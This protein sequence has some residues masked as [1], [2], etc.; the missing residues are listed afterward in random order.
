MNKKELIKNIKF[1]INDFIA[2]SDV[3]KKN[4]GEVMT[5]LYLVDD[6]L[7]LLPSDVWSNPKLKW[8]DPCNGVGTF[9]CQIVDR[10]MTGLK[11][12]IPNEEERYSHIIQKMI[13]T[14]EV[15]EKNVKRFLNI[16]NP[17]KEYNINFFIGDFLSEEFSEFM[18]QEWGVDKFDV[19]IMNSP[20]QTAS[21]G[22]HHRSRPLYNLFI[23]K[24]ILISDKI[25]S[26]HP[27]RWMSKSMGL[28]R[29]KNMMLNRN[30]I[31]FIRT[32]NFKNK[33]NLFGDLV[34]IR[35]GFQ[36]ILIDKEYFGLVDYDGV[37]SKLND[38]DIFVESKFHDIVKKYSLNNI[39]LSSICESNSVF[40]NFHNDELSEY[41]KE[42]FIPCYVAH[43][44]G[45]LKYI[46]ESK[47]MKKGKKLINSWKVFT[48]FASGYGVKFNYFGS[49]IIGKPGEVCSNTFLTLKVNS[50][51]EAESLI[52]YME[53][54]FCCFFLSLRKKTQNMNKK[55]LDWIP[56]VPL[57]RFWNDE[58]L[59]EYFNLNEQDIELIINS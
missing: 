51:K 50:E 4:F 57:D 15:Q 47:I 43:R 3:D 48:P 30:D 52:S 2:D 26:V 21:V 14:C 9:P 41:S 27:S 5:P 33:H 25:L 22:K 53:T 58:L 56:L 55:T 18:I 17:T 12:E 13:Y 45:N 24:A 49:K 38:F 44:K 32:F 37:M 7:D 1:A 28:E 23:E 54:K 59:F 36:Y 46:E 11:A 34:E 16:F 29:F 35:G 31:K 8:L 19:L 20:Y 6:M 10:L 42:G 39:G 40:M